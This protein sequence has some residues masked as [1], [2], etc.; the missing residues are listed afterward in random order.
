MKMS[1]ISVVSLIVVIA[2]ALIGCEASI[3]SSEEI[4][5]TQ[6]ITLK[7]DGM[8]CKMCPITIKTAI[9]KLDGVENADVSYNDKEAKVLYQQDKVTVDEI[10]TAIENAGNYKA[11]TVSTKN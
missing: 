10:I 7:V 2:I 3:S 5:N 11:T 8:T 6:E 9:K 1:T 4:T